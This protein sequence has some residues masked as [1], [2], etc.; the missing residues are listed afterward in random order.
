MTFLTRLHSL[1]RS[2]RSER[3]P[4]SRFALL[5]LYALPFAFTATIFKVDLSRVVKG[6]PRCESAKGSS[7]IRCV[8]LLQIDLGHLCRLSS[9]VRLD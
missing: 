2:R 6:S 8:T 7:T 9:G 1:F 5:E 3:R 4:Q